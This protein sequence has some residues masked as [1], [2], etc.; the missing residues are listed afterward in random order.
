MDLE[1]AP[2]IDKM[3]RVTCRIDRLDDGAVLRMRPRSTGRDGSPEIVEHVPVK[4]NPLSWSQPDFPDSDPIGLGQEPGADTAV[5][6][7]CLELLANGGGPIR[8]GLLGHTDG[9]DCSPWC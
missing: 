1:F 6:L 8:L 3:T 4:S 7:I 2:A 9:H 5:E